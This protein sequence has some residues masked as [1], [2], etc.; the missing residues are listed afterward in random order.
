MGR[1]AERRFTLWL[2][3]PTSSGKTTLAELLLRRLRRAGVPAMHYD[4]DE[5]R[6]FFGDA[7]GFAPKDRLRVVSTLTHLANKTTGA[8]LNVIVSALSAN[9]DARRH[10]G[11]TVE[12]LIIVYVKCPID[13]CAG[14]DPKGLY[15][16]A[17]RGEIDT[18][19]GLNSEYL[20]PDDPDLVVDT[21]ALSRDQAVDAVIG[22]LIENGWIGPEPS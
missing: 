9:P 12:N 21:D 13:V 19:I 20:A 6:D 11:E 8:G 14:R 4:G 16:R 7:L 1:S 10:I 5:V 17:G 18:L 2:M 3:G 15:A 22:H